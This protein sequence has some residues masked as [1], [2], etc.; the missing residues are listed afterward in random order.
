MSS[1]LL[2]RAKLQVP[3]LP[4]QCSAPLI[5]YEWE[6]CVRASVL[7]ISIGT[8][9]FF[10][11]ITAILTRHSS[12]DDRMNMW[13]FGLKSVLRVSVG[14]QSHA[15]N[16]I[17]CVGPGRERPSRVNGKP[18]HRLRVPDCQR[19][20]KHERAT[21]QFSPFPSYRSSLL[22]FLPPLVLSSRTVSTNTATATSRASAGVRF[23]FH[24]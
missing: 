16:G 14:F 20:T 4:E 10:E 2:P 6:W 15:R 1:Y 24:L 23:F 21:H 13:D 3:P 9:I 8:A 5:W 19:K 22:L 12:D 18:D 17:I 7:G 11:S